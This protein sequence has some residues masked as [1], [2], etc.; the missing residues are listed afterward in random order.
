MSLALGYFALWVVLH[1]AI[2]ILLLLRAATLS[3]FGIDVAMASVVLDLTAE[4]TPP[5]FWRV[6]NVSAKPEQPKGLL[7]NLAHSHIYNDEDALAAIAAFLRDERL[8]ALSQPKSES[9]A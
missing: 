3:L 5:G 7:G 4:V 2:A 9:S 6:L 8:V 1:T